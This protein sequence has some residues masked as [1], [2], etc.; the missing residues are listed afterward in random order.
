MVVHSPVPVESRL[1]LR[2]EF[3]DPVALF[4][5]DARVSWC[6]EE[7]LDIVQ[8]YAVGIRFTGTK[9]QHGDGEWEDLVRAHMRGAKSPP[10]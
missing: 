4:E 7:S 2:V 3:V 6:R 1:R 8:S 9:R 10:L 5:H